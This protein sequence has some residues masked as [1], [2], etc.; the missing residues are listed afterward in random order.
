MCPFGEFLCLQHS[1][2]ASS[3]TLYPEVSKQEH[4]CGTANA[5]SRHLGEKNKYHIYIS[6]SEC[7]RNWLLLGALFS[8]Y[9]LLAE[10]HTHSDENLLKEIKK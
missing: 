10:L 2:L 1:A 8:S 3:L 6:F 7:K 5:S 9:S 4:F